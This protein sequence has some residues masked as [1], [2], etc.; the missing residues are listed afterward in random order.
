MFDKLMF[1]GV[2]VVA[3]AFGGLTLVVLAM[4]LRQGHFPF[5]PRRTGTAPDGDP[6]ALRRSEEPVLYWL[7]A[8]GMAAAGVIMLVVAAVTGQKALFGKT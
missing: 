5:R 4:G 3:A 2:A 1:G 8:G 7:V 6:R